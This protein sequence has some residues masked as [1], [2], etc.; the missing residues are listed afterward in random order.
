MAGYQ[1]LPDMEEMMKKKQEKGDGE[2]LEVPEI[3]VLMGQETI[4][5]FSKAKMR[6]GGLR[7]IV[8]VVD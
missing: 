3:A 2:S 7:S 8:F 5:I 4:D 1:D 6:C